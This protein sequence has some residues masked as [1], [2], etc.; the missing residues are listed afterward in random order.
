MPRKRDFENLTSKTASRSIW[1]KSPA[2]GLCPASEL[3]KDEVRFVQVRFCIVTR[4]AMPYLGRM[5][6][7]PV[8][9]PN[10]IIRLLISVFICVYCGS[11]LVSLLQPQAV[12]KLLVR[13]YVMGGA[14]L[15]C[16]AIAL[17]LLRR[18]WEL[19]E[20][21]RRVGVTLGFFY[22]GFALGAVAQKW[23]GVSAPNVAQMVISA[24][25]FQGAILIL[26][27]FFL[28]EHG[29]GWRESFGLERRWQKAVL[30]GLMVA[31]LFLPMAWLLQKTSMMV[32]DHLPYLSLH[33]EEQQAVRTI[34]GATALGERIT[35]GIVTIILAP[36]S[37][38][39]LFRGVLY[40]G[41]RDAGFSRLALWGNS[42]LFAAVHMNAATFLPLLLLAVVL[43]RL[44][45]R[46]GN[47][48][49]CISTHSLFNALN[50]ALLFWTSAGA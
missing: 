12:G 49:A 24:I 18:P 11:L 25:A 28:R 9:K 13:V 2:R 6:S 19:E 27:I 33:P 23:A 39:L 8:W 10:A 47:L 26:L 45:E 36:L 50:F 46:T 16:L 30:S 7:G 42:A 34:R 29:S 32:L 38:E 43:T 15:L 3:R 41:I 31:I 21:T 37:E 14:S 20:L 48:L 44:Y 4:A 1:R 22:A 35:L 40:P 17:V 5:Q